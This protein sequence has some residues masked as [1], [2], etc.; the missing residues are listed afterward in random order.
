MKKLIAIAAALTLAACGGGDDAADA[1]SDS[2]PAA[3][4]ASDMPADS[5]GTYVGTGAD[6]EEVTTTLNADGTFQDTVGGEVIRSGTWEDA[7][8]GTCFVEEGV[9]GEMCYNMG[10]PGPDGTVE[11]TGPDGVTTTMRKTA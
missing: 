3:S 6:G 4:S 10:A 7:M 11:V 9:E 2:A 1:G 5:T 8:R